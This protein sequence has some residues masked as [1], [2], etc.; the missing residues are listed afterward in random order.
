M[1]PRTW[2]DPTQGG[3]GQPTLHW[4][5]WSKGERRRWQFDLFVDVVFVEQRLELVVG[6]PH[7]AQQNA[8]ATMTPAYTAA[9]ASPAAAPPWA[10]TPSATPGG[11]V[12]TPTVVRVQLVQ[13][14]L[15]A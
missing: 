14:Q 9:S 12:P 11:V 7:T 5:L 15:L 4:L 13:D 1:S 10:S 6:A 8:N 3:R 2:L